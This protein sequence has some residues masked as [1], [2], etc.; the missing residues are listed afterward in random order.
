MDQLMSLENILGLY[1]SQIHNH[2]DYFDIVNYLAENFDVSHINVSR[3]VD[4]TWL[5]TVFFQNVPEKY[6][7]KLNPVILEQIKQKSP[8]GSWNLY[9]IDKNKLLDLKLKLEANPF[10]SQF[11]LSGDDG[12][13]KMFEE[14]EDDE[15]HF[16]K[17]NHL[18]FMVEEWVRT[19]FV[20]EIFYKSD[21]ES[22]YG[23]N[24]KIAGVLLKEYSEREN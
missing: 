3:M 22:P 5:R 6:I 23:L 20:N 4:G 21:F 1:V 11:D 24:L 18:T 12:F 7:N 13:G 2:D 15:Y 17:S 14:E 16:L 19:C 9:L 8:K 10:D